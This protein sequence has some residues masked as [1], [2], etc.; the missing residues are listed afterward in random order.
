M[1]NR[2]LKK[3]FVAALNA[4]RAWSTDRAGRCKKV[5]GPSNSVE[6]AAGVLL[7]FT[8][9]PYFQLVV[10]THQRH[11]IPVLIFQNYFSIFCVYMD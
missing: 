3:V 2:K 1:K 6:L 10:C 8:S 5:E 7:S 4:T 9:N 11:I